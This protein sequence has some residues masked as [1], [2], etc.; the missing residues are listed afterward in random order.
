VY[1][2]AAFSEILTFPFRGRLEKGV[3]ARMSAGREKK[4]LWQEK[5]KTFFGKAERWLFNVET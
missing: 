3:K 4:M 2:S 1:S 5:T